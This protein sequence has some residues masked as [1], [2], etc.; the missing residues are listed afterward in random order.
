MFLSVIRHHRSDGNGYSG[1][2]CAMTGNPCR[3][4]PDVLL[5]KQADDSIGTGMEQNPQQ[6]NSDI[7]HNLTAAMDLDGSNLTQALVY[8]NDPTQRTLENRG[9]AV[10][11][12][13]RFVS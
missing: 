1:D 11:I 2:R 13:K 6:I 4:L 5:Y 10:G 7:F 12:T 9:Q 3:I 8:L